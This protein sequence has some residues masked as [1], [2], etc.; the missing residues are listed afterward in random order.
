[1]IRK[2]CVRRIEM[3]DYE[4]RQ[5]KLLQ[6]FVEKNSDKH[7]TIEE[8]GKMIAGISVSALY[9]NVNQMVRGGTLRRFRQ[10]GQRKLLY[11]YIGLGE[12]SEHLHLK[13]SK[14]GMILHV[15]NDSTNSFVRELRQNL[16]FELDK[17]ATI[18]FG[19]CITCKS[20]SEV[21]GA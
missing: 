12:C 11:Q 19:D 16:H 5:R 3:R 20:N 14:C 10:E 1:M 2:S 7:F 15:D 9:R 18:L 13:C 8:L 21:S 17:T 4:T 6:D